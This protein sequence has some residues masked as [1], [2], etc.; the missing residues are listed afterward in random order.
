MVAA[1][2]VYDGVMKRLLVTL[3][4]VVFIACRSDSSEPDAG[5]VD[6]GPHDAG[7]M[8]AGPVDSGV[9]GCTIDGRTWLDGDVNPDDACQVCS[10]SSARSAWSLRADGTSCGGGEVC[11]AGTCAAKCFIDGVIV[12]AAAAN[13]VNPC[14]V[15]NPMMTT[16]AW[17]ARSDG[18][19]CGAGQVCAGGVC[20]SQCFLDAALVDAGTVNASNPCEICEPSSA[21]TEWSLRADGT[22][23]GSGQLCLQGQCEAKCIIDGGAI[24]AGAVN[25][26][27]ECEWC[28]PGSSTS[29]WSPRAEVMLLEGGVDVAAQGW[30]VVAL[31]PSSLTLDGGLTTLSTS[32]MGSAGTGGQLLLARAG[33][34]PLTGDYT[35]RV[36]AEV[37]RVNVHNALDCGAALLGAFNGAFGSGAERAQ[38]ICLDPSAVVWGDDT[39]SAPVAIVDAGLRTYE[40]SVTAANVATVSVDGVPVLARPGFQRNGTIAI[41]D[42]TNDRNT[43]GQMSIRSVSRI[44]Q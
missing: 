40:L 4:L 10:T 15:C 21:T 12:D 24:D 41:G 19:A 42:Q 27:A 13:P 1:G 16:G 9:A 44:C 36:R 7:A 29:Q 2:R 35:L 26:S 30:V 39:Q 25:P 33:T 28:E 22:A 17:S 11:R 20:A 3:G 8:D 37:T 38:M 14:E 23:C 43:D 6:A 18:S 5:T 31:Q 32:T 34:T